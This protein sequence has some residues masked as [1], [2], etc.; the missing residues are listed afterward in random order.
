MNLFETIYEKKFQLNKFFLK[1]VFIVSFI[2]VASNFY[3]WVSKKSFYEY[4]DWL[5]NYQG[6]LARRGFIGEIFFQIINKKK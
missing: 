4:S 1:C 5:I 3:K 6:G 2:T